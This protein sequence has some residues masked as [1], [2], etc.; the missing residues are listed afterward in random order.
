MKNKFYRKHLSLNKVTVAHLCPRQM[1]SA[2]GGCGTDTLQDT[3]CN[4]ENTTVLNETYEK[5]S[6]N[7]CL[8]Q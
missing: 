4:I 1:Y 8:T 3:T 6:A 2:R 5:D 7:T